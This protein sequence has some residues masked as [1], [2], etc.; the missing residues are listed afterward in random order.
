MSIREATL[1]DVAQIS[2]LVIN[3]VIPHKHDDFSEEAWSFFEKSNDYETTK[4]RLA[5]PDYFTLCYE[6]NGEILG[7]ITIKQCQ[8]IDQLYVLPKAWRKGIAKKLWRTAKNR[9]MENGCSG[10]FRVISSSYAMPIYKSFGF[11]PGERQTK[12]GITF[13]PMTL[14]P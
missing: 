9:C 14:T 4:N 7:I 2:R 3:S 6:V 11:V 12:N 1:Q 8:S 5:N 13:Y 10:A